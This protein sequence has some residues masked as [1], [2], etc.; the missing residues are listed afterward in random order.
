MHTQNELGWEKYHKVLDK[1]A[2]LT[3]HGKVAQVIG[4]TIEGYGVGSYVGE[5]C[6]IHAQGSD[7]PLKAEIIGFRDNRVILMP[8]GEIHGIG[9]GSRITGLKRRATIAV[10]EKMLGRVIDG[11]GNSID[12][13]GPL[14]GGVEYP[15]FS[16]PINPLHRKRI[17]NQLI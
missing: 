16:D 11:L 5:L 8:L 14:P 10:G 17:E 4:M 12:G 7:V 3:C 13:K 2:L 9:P 6:E 15:L 1:A